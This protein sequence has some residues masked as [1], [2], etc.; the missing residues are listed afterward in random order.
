MMKT[1]LTKEKEE[2]EE[3][4]KEEEEEEE[5]QTYPQCPMNPHWTYT[6]PRHAPPADYFPV[7]WGGKGDRHTGAQKLL[8]E[9]GASSAVSRGNGVQ[10]LER[11]AFHDHGPSQV[12]YCWSFASSLCIILE[13]LGWVPSAQ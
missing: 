6:Q 12:K 11:R 9:F 13:R 1:R 2:E 3:K 10:E 8:Q 4:K 5:D 7:L